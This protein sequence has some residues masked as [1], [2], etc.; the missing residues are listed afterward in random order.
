MDSP[1]NQR[2]RILLADDHSMVRQSLASVLGDSP[3]IDVVGQ[4]GNGADLLKLL[5]AQVVDVLVIDYS[6]PG[7]DIVDTIA[8][9]KRISPGI[10][11]LVLTV[12]E[13]VHYAARVLEN[14]ANGFVIKASAVD[15]LV[16]AIV[17]VHRN[18]MFI[19]P[20]LSAQVM[21]QLRIPR[22]IRRG[23]DTLSNRE[24]EFVRLFATGISL[25][26]C[27]E[28]MNVTQSTASTYRIRVMEKLNLQNTND[29]I[30][31]ALENRIAD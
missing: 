12:H 23:L 21:A 4:A 29:I 11:C 1:L 5:D 9:A 25:Q 22:R 31:Y 19:S 30:R 13:N 17:A 20:L 2:I 26:A 27:A 8:N 24:L 28:K 10:K 16:D 18:E 3:L 6:M 15:E 7:T 14:G